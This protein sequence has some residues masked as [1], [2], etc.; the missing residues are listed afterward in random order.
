MQFVFNCTWLK[1]SQPW[2]SI[3]I[4][5][6]LCQQAKYILDRLSARC[7]ADTETDNHRRLLESLINP[8]NCTRQRKFKLLHGKKKKVIID[9]M[10]IWF[11]LQLELYWMIS[12]Q[13][14]SHKLKTGGLSG[15]PALTQAASPRSSVTLEYH[16]GKGVCCMNWIKTLKHEYQSSID[17]LFTQ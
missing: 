5:L 16:H 3:W 15:F 2:L 6:D 13:K 10:H 14:Y 9:I 17:T 12:A 4:Y 7:R 11:T 8:T 1:L